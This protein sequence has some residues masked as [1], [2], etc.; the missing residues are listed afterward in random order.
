[1]R[2]PTGYLPLG[3]GSLNIG[4]AQQR[5]RLAAT[6]LAAIIAHNTLIR[7]DA[8]APINNVEGQRQIG[9][10]HLPMQSLKPGVRSSSN[11]CNAGKE[12][13]GRRLPRLQE[14]DHAQDGS[15]GDKP[16]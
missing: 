1:M 9:G 16:L 2:V 13:H 12:Q 6:M 4:K 15:T 5:T 7:G 10:P 8:V 3:A 11:G 14:P